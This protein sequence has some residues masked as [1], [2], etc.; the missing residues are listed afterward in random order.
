MKESLE[1]QLN[2]GLNTENSI[3]STKNLFK[4]QKK[5]DENIDFIK[6]I[7][8]KGEIIF[9][10][11]EMDKDTQ[12]NTAWVNTLNRESGTK[13]ATTSKDK[14]SKSSKNQK[15]DTDTDTDTNEIIQLPETNKAIIIG[16]PFV[17]SFGSNEGAVI[18]GY[19]KDYLKGNVD[20]MIW[21]LAQGGVSI[22]IIFIVIT[23]VGVYL[24]LR[25]V[26]KDFKFM[27]SAL[28]EHSSKL[29]YLSGKKPDSLKNFLTFNKARKDVLN[30]IDNVENNSK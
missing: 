8:S 7:N 10:T 26:T 9:T 11:N 20:G 21:L 5:S 27:A 14:T 13:K 25:N 28:G 18:L 29:P 6:V 12:A 2:L 19:S 22:F 3:E 23:I 4:E 24:Y 17:N 15:T 16:L 1:Y 30:D